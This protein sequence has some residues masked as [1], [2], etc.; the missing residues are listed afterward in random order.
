MLSRLFQHDLRTV[1]GQN[2]KKIA[3]ICGTSIEDLTPIMVKNTVKYRE[4]PA[5]EEWRLG[6]IFEI[7]EARQN[8]IGMDGLSR[9]DLEEILYYTCTV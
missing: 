2:L 4:L 7:L 8:N 1:Y 6:V 3:D 5:E 9:R